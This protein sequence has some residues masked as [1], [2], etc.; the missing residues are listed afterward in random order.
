MFI[1]F[2]TLHALSLRPPM[3]KPL[4][5]TAL[6]KMGCCLDVQGPGSFCRIL[7]TLEQHLIAI[8]YV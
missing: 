7:L 5:V 3:R 6:I 4:L 1:T 2:H 8:I